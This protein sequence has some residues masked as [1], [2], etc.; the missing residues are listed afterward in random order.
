MK[1]KVEL[2]YCTRYTDDKTNQPKSLL[3]YRLLESNF[4]TTTDKMKGYLVLLIGSDTHKLFNF[5]KPEHF[6]QPAEIEVIEV[7]NPSNPMRTSKTLKSVKIG[8]DIISLL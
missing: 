7:P 5:L 6:G 8:N 2:L 3:N 1:L 4:I